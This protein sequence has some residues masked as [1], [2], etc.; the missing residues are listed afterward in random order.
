[1]VLG[2]WFLVAGSWFL[3]AGCWFLVPGS[4]AF[5]PTPDSLN[6]KGLTPSWQASWNFKVSKTQGITVPRIAGFPW[7]WWWTV[8]PGIVRII[9]PAANNSKWLEIS[10]FPRGKMYEYDWNV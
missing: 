3:V 2:S 5:I 6:K 8:M 10:K 1:M 7:W 9:F 4:A